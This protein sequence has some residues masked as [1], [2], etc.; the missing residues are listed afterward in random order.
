MEE[1]KD[2]N[3]SGENFFDQLENAQPAVPIKKLQRSKNNIVIAGVCSGLSEFSG[4]DVANVRLIALMSLLLGWWSVA[5]YLVMAMLLPS[6]QN[7]KQ[8][9]A[10]E[11]EI[12][13]KENF[14]TVLSGL[15]IVVGF[16]FSL[17]AIGIEGGGRIF[18][19]PG[20][21]ILP[22]ISFITGI[23]LLLTKKEEIIIEKVNRQ[24]FFRSQSNKIFMG[25]CGG[26]GNYT[27]IDSTALRIFFVLASLLTLG[28]FAV[29]YLMFSVFTSFDSEQKIEFE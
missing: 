5:A 3:K 15:L 19:F 14:R 26:L 20:G 24:K 1:Q 11:K 6:E 29:V 18:I 4:A 12:Q 9:T 7:P 13:R 25:V 21:F 16:Y 8:L 23:Y 2:Q 28:L 10:E 27:N 22:V 17:S